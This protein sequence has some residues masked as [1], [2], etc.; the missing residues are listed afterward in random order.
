MRSGWRPTTETRRTLSGAA[1]AAPGGA[2][3]VV[4]QEAAWRAARAAAAN[5][6]A[7]VGRWYMSGADSD[8]QRRGIRPAERSRRDTSALISVLTHPQIERPSSCN[9]T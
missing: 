3:A 2:S 8:Y 9:R 4:R 1:A 6:A 7:L 5:R